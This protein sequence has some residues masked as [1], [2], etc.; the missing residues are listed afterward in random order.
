MDG[1]RCLNF[2]FAFQWNSCLLITELSVFVHVCQI[3]I[4]LMIERV[5]KLYCIKLCKRLLILR[6]KQFVRF[7]IDP[8]HSSRMI[9]TFFT[10]HGIPVVCPPIYFPEM[11]PCE[12]LLFLKV[13]FLKASGCSE[14]WR[15][16]WKSPILRVEMRYTEFDSKVEHHSNRRF[17]KYFR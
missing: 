16:H 14:N 4:S 2:S 15:R 3:L 13:F 9:Q 7:V 1:N 10:K 6:A 11:T 12:F 17:Q 5:E 8:A